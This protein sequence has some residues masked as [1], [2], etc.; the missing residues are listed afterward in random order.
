MRNILVHG[1][2][3]LDDAKVWDALGRLDDLRAFAA[4]AAELAASS[5]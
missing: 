5:Q 3:E 4:W 2:L 1:Y